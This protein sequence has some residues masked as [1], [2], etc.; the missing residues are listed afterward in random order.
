MKDTISDGLYISFVAT[1][2]YLGVNSLH[3][4]LSLISVG[5]AILVG[6]GRFALIVREWKAKR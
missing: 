5:F 2:A 1:L 6:I 3:D 4:V